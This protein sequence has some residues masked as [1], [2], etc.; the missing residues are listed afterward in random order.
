MRNKCDICKQKISRVTVCPSCLRQ[1]CINCSF[2]G[3]C[4]DCFYTE[5][6]KEFLEDYY[7]EKYLNVEIK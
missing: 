6:Q 3:L 5:N 7:K 4:Y 1:I 2:S